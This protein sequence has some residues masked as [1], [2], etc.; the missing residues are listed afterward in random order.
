I[1]LNIPFLAANCVDL[2]LFQFSSRR[3]TADIFSIMGFGDDLMNTLPKMLLDFWVEVL[4]LIILSLSLAFLYKKFKLHRADELNANGRLSRSVLGVAFFSLLFISFRGGVQLKPVSILTASGNGLHKETALVLNSSFTIIK[5]I[6]KQELHKME[7]FSQSEADRLMPVIHEY[8][9]EFT[10]K[11]IVII[12]LEGIGKEYIGCLNAGKGYTP[13]LDSLFSQSLIFTQAY[14]NGKRSIEGIPAVVAGIPSLCDQPYISSPYSG[15]TITSIPNLLKPYGYSSV[16]FHGGTNGTM[17]FDGFS[18]VAGFDKYFGRTEYAD[19]SGFDGNWGI[20]DMPFLQRMSKELDATRQ[21]FVATVFT[22]TSHHP[23]KVPEPYDTLLPKGDLAIHQSVRYADESLRKFFHVAEKKEWFSN[24]VFVITSDHTS[25]SQYP[26]YKTP[27]GIYAI[28]IAY[29]VP[30]GNLIGISDRTTQQID[31]LPSVMDLIAYPE[32]FFSFGNSVFDSTSYP[33]AISH[34]HGDYQLIHDNFA[35]ALD[36]I[37]GG[38]LY[39]HVSDTSFY[40][41]LYRHKPK[42]IKVLDERLK[43]AIQ[44]YTTSLLDNRM[45]VKNRK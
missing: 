26:R 23:Y 30:N 45:S 5:T 20:Y 35:Y 37:N 10:K 16:F 6:G 17:N 4:L 9:G 41:N 28:P 42:T 25:L 36:T 44:Q 29:F 39:D 31:I 8:S 32:P 15:N 38:T 11:N 2:G 22:L 43:A 14:A 24:T 40:H 7:F 19:D 13:F 1:L 12:I 27:T 3:L 21:P 34:L 33:F 18:A